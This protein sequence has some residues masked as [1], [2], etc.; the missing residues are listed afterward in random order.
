V[1]TENTENND[2][3]VHVDSSEITYAA[4]QQGAE[5]TTCEPKTLSE[6]KDSME[7]LEWDKAIQ[8]ELTQLIK[9][10]TWEMTPLPTERKAIGNRW[11]FAKKYNKDG[12]LAKYK[13]RLVAKGYSQV[14]GMDYTDTFSPVVRLETIRVLFALNGTLKEEIYMQQPDGFDDGTRLLPCG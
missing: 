2:D 8:A 4:A 7:W 6:A 13:A 1:E 3:D 10:G 11:V 12:S 5:T 14:P 9:M